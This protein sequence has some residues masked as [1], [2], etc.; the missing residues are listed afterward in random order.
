MPS[1]TIGTLYQLSE[2]YLTV[3][4]PDAD[5]RGRTVVDRHGDEVGKV[6]DLLVDERE[7]KVRFLRVGE[8]GFLGLGK[9]HYLVPV[10]VV[11][12][13]DRDRVRIDRERA[14]MGDV[15]VYDPELTEGPDQYDA[16]YGWWG[17]A[18]YWSTGYRYP[19]FPAGP[20]V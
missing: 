10:D 3:A 16:V 8:G 9:T 4:D 2:T 12:A 14:E 11:V 5:V 6:E 18:P 1:E 13:V 15:P 20:F 17:T 7:N 19:G